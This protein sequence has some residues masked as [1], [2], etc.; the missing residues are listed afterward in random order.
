[1]R[2][3][4]T[5]NTLDARAGSELYV[6]DVATGL[7]DRGHTPVAFS[8]ILGEVARNLRAAT[9]PVIDSLDAL[10]TPPDIIHGQHHVETMMAMLHFPNTPAVY[11]C[12]GWLPWEEAPPRFPRILKYIA[13]DH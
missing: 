13:V 5:N 3:L 2:I 6:R 8:T 10:T 11:F 9:I 12:H 4:I 7:L 1:M